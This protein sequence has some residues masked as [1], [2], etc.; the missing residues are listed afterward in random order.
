MSKI[1]YTRTC[2]KDVFNAFLIRSAY[3]AG[4]FEFPVLQGTHDIP[5][6]V[7]SFSKAI[8]SKD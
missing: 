3:F 1:N 7:I 8:G 2:C 5:N 6:R 4:L